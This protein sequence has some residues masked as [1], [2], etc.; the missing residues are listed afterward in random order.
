[1]KK[2][3]IQVPHL[4]VRFEIITDS[5]NLY[6]LI[7]KVFSHFIIVN[8]KEGVIIRTISVETQQDH[9]LVFS[10]NQLYLSCRSD[11]VEV[12]ISA[13]YDIISASFDC[14]PKNYSFYHSFV[15]G[16]EKRATL[17]VAPTH[18]GKT[19]LGT[20]LTLNG[21]SYLS[22]DVA[23]INEKGELIPYPL[24][25]K[26]RKTPLLSKKQL[27]KKYEIM[28][29][30][31]YDFLLPREIEI[32]FFTPRS[33][34]FLRRNLDDSDRTEYIEEINKSTALQL[35]INNASHLNNIVSHV[36]SATGLLKNC[37]RVFQI[38]FGSGLRVLDTIVGEIQ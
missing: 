1:M 10:N 5:P 38:S 26:L 32:D 15:V 17:L 25:I 27:T 9:F 23:I 20:A 14:F 7:I 13:I 22:D 19:T 21:F 11:R 30:V 28:E 12:I 6:A 16:N 8:S 35:L 34:V 33:I 36:R 31:S 37:D 2:I 29:A 24:P 4:S 18:Q 3:S